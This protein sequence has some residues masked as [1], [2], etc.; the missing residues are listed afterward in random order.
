MLFFFTWNENVLKEE[1]TRDAF[2]NI[3]INF[4][5]TLQTVF[6]FNPT[7]FFFVFSD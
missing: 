4:F 6:F 5:F 1:A 7:T 3:F 2:K